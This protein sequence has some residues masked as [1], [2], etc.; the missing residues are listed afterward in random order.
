MHQALERRMVGKLAGGVGDAFRGAGFVAARPRLWGWVLAPAA[1]ALAILVAVIWTLVRISEPAVAW[2]AGFLP[3]FL[4]HGLGGLLTVLLVAALAV[5][6]Y[7]VFFAVAALVSAPFNEMLSEAI[8]KEL[9]GVE[10]SAFSLPT[11]AYELVVGLVHATRRVIAYL[12]T[13][14]LLALVGLLVPVIGPPIA[15]AGGVVAS[16]RF[17]A[18]DAYDA[19]W[20]RKGVRYRDKIAYLRAHRGESYGLGAAVALLALIPAL[21]LLAL[22]IGAAGA[23]LAYVEGQPDKYDG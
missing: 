11:F 1:L 8:E 2:M 4:Q 21:N 16:A 7:F 5:A 15:V 17:A 6:G 23:T 19:V 10:P 13:T 12:F 22:S 18:Y 9:T 3:Q 14:A 20:A